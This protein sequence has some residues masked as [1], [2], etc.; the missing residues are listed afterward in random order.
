MDAS[1]REQAAVRGYVRALPRPFPMRPAGAEVKVLRGDVTAFRHLDGD[2][3]E[4]GRVWVL[5]AVADTG[6]ARVELPVARRRVILVHVDGT[7][8]ELPVSGNRLAVELKGDSKMTPPVLVVDRPPE[9][10]Q[11]AD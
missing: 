5:W 2:G 4:A 9:D 7:T 3:P 8:S 1:E 6:D 11:R 10:G